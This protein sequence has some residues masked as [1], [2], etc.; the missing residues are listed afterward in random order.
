VFVL[1]HNKRRWRREKAVGWCTSY[2]IVLT[3]VHEMRYGGI[4]NSV[5]L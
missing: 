1:R 3:H 5:A 2:E 4:S